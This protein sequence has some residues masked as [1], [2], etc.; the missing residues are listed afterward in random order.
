MDPSAGDGGVPV[1]GTLK[2]VTQ[3]CYQFHAKPRVFEYILS[4]REYSVIRYLEEGVLRVLWVR[5]Q[6]NPYSN[7]RF[8][9]GD[10]VNEGILNQFAGNEA[11]QQPLFQGKADRLNFQL[12]LFVAPYKRRL[13]L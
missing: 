11:D 6:R 9:G 2:L 3:R 13:D 7:P 1:N 5:L 12:K 8:S 4:L 10:R